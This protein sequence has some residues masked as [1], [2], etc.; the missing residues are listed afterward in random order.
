[1]QRPY[2]IYFQQS[3]TLGASEEY[4]YL[5]MQDIDRT[6]FNIIFVCPESSI[7]DSLVR[8]IEALGIKV[9]RYSLNTSNYLV[10]LR[11]L[12]FFRKF[13]PELVHINDPCL[14]GIIAA[15]LANAPVLL[16]THHTPELN[17]KYN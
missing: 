13:K 4:F 12:W 2:I 5:L 7:L 10:I 6:R 15:R 1:M 8:K 16:I 3:L 11:L 17:R 14:I 9:Q